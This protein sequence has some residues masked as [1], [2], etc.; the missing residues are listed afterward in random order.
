MN[1]GMELLPWSHHRYVLESNRGLAHISS[2][3]PLRHCAISLDLLCGI[4]TGPDRVFV[5]ENV[6]DVNILHEEL[7]RL[8]P[9]LLESRIFLV[10]WV[11]GDRVNATL[12]Q[13]TSRS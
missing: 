13:T 4:C 12:T 8:L 2:I 7:I 1:P 5:S 9:N 11:E 3:S 10:V 6:L